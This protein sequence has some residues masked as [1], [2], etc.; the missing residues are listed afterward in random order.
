MGTRRPVSPRDLHEL[1]RP[2]LAR[3]GSKN[4]E[5]A[6]RVRR[7]H[8]QGP[9]RRDDTHA[10]RHDRLALTAAD[11]LAA[12]RRDESLC[13]AGYDRGAPAL[14]HAGPSSRWD[15]LGTAPGLR[16][17]QTVARTAAAAES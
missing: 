9:R 7:R 13:D 12:S 4:P 16:A 6:A 2:R 14:T 8:D 15:R 1:E 10:R 17:R 5:P 11:V 3:D